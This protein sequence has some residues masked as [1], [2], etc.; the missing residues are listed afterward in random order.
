MNMHIAAALQPSNWPILS[1]VFGKGGSGEGAQAA[2]ADLDA[3]PPAASSHGW[4]QR[5]KA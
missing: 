2:G 5:A 1:R 4:Y 3:S